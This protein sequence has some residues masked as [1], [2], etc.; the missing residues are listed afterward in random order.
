LIAIA[1]RDE[2]LLLDLDGEHPVASA[3]SCSARWD[4][5]SQ[6][7]CPPVGGHSDHLTRRCWRS[8][9]R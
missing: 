2:H 9:R 7:E 8:G 5:S 4:E 6:R 3:L 1:A